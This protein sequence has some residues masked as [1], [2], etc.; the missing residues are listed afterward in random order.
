MK[1]VELVVVIRSA[2]NIKHLVNRQKPAWCWTKIKCVKTWL[3]K[4]VAPKFLNGRKICE[5]TKLFTH[6]FKHT[7][8]YTRKRPMPCCK[9]FNNPPVSSQPFFAVSYFV[10][11]LLLL[12]DY[13]ALL[14]K[15][16]GTEV[17]AHQ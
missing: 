17:L 13:S 14:F 11:F 15:A 1:R 4:N 7:L 16:N 3:E 12:A 10:T 9:T 5:L 2:V 6:F 8:L